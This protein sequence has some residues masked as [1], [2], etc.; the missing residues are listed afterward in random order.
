[1]EVKVTKCANGHYYDV[2]KYDA[3]PHC[4][5]GE[6]VAKEPQKKK[7]SLFKNNA[8]KSKEKKT[9]SMQF[10][11]EVVKQAE[12][13]VC[14][15]VETVGA[16]GANQLQADD[17]ET[18]GVFAATANAESA[19]DKVAESPRF[20]SADLTTGFFS[21]PVEAEKPSATPVVES[22]PAPADCDVKTTGFFSMGATTETKTES[23]LEQVQAVTDD[24][25][26]KTTGFFAPKKAANHT[27]QN[28]QQPPVG[29]L[30]CLTGKHIGKDYRI[31]AGKNSIGR[32]EE[33]A[34]ALLGET[35]VSREKHAWVI[36]EPKKQEFF[37]KSGNESGLVYLNEESVF[38]ITSLHTGDILELGNVK[39]VFVALCGENFNWN[40]YI[41]K[42]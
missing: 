35:G 16:Y 42:E 38:D 29:W 21:A 39:M 11:K 15:D 30:V 27:E 9:E 23:L 13:L 34:V 3:C 28:V 12:D 33:N 31:F 14:E 25:D 2:N 19:E 20:E 6:F 37:L 17:V 18:Q 22:S 24:N 36:F 10:S 8:T 26:A 1:M 41:N 32:T 4:G 7:F 5:A 40:N